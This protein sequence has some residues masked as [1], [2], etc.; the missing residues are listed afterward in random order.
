MRVV[1]G[2][3][4]VG[5]VL[6]YDCRIMMGYGGSYQVKATVLA[7]KGELIRIEYRKRRLTAQDGR[8]G[9]VEGAVVRRWVD[10]RF[11]YRPG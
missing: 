11:L 5:D 9:G 3:W 4:Q 6:G 7:V 1:D 8:W 2:N 10:R